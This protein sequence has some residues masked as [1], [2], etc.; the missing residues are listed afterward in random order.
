M[1]TEHCIPPD[2]LPREEG[3]ELDAAIS[4][5]NE[6]CDSLLGKLEEINRRLGREREKLG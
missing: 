2:F 5:L 6:A 4:R 1:I 3:S